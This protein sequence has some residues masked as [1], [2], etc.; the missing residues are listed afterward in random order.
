MDTQRNFSNFSLLLLSLLRQLLVEQNPAGYSQRKHVTRGKRLQW[1]STRQCAGTSSLCRILVFFNDLPRE[2]QSFVKMFAND[3]KVYN[4][5][6][7]VKGPQELQDLNRLQEGSDR[8]LHRFHPQ[9]CKV[10]KLG[11]HRSEAEYAMTAKGN[12]Q[13][14][15]YRK[16]NGEGPGSVR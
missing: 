9:K 16:H 4:R 2:V 3:S 11:A 5:S 6:D 7:K 13:H 14:Q 10:L 12:N 15:A 1:N 8:W